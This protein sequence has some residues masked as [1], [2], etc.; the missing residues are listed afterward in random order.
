MTP[1]T[2]TVRVL[3]SGEPLANTSDQAAAVMFSNVSS[4]VNAKVTTHSTSLTALRARREAAATTWRTTDSM[5]SAMRPV[6][7]ATTYAMTAAVK[8]ALSAADIFATS[9]RPMAKVTVMF[10]A[11][12]TANRSQ[13][14][15]CSRRGRDQR[16]S[17]IVGGRHMLN[18]TSD[19]DP[20]AGD[21]MVLGSPQELA[22]DGGEARGGGN[23]GVIRGYA[24]GD[25]CTHVLPRGPCRLANTRSMPGERGQWAVR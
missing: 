15:A 21:A 25:T 16:A 9:A 10:S 2:V 18:Y 23:G 13:A 6:S 5:S 20:Y 1:P 22:R 8:F 24:Y 11:A 3:S 19:T 7:N 4:D 14:T 12:Q 17:C